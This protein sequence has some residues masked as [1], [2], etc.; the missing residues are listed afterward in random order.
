MITVRG[1]I[2]IVKKVSEG[3]A[4]TS[5][6]NQGCNIVCD[7]PPRKDTAKPMKFVKSVGVLP[8]QKSHFGEYRS[9]KQR[10]LQG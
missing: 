9:G 3:E 7:N 4:T 5:I 8:S 2:R 6:G 10:A 1:H